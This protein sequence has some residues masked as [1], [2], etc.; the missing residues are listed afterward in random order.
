MVEGSGTTDTSPALAHIPPFTKRY[1]HPRCLMPID[2]QGK[3]LLTPR[4]LQ[5]LELVCQGHSSKQIAD[6]LGLGYS[7][8]AYHRVRLMTRARVHD[9]NSLLLWALEKGYIRLGDGLAPPSPATL[10]K[11]PPSQLTTREAPR[12]FDVS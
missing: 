7:T 6:L 1:P 2:M 4:Q 10:Q 8:V 5:V 11:H 3:P 9:S 12:C